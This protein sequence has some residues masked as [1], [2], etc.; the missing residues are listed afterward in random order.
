MSQLPRMLPTEKHRL[1]DL[2]QGAGLDVSDWANFK[3]KNPSQNPKYCYQWSF[4]VPN[5]ALILNIWHDQIKERR[6]GTIYLELNIR[7]FGSQRKGAEKRR[8]V[9]MD[10]GL[11][12]AA[13][14]RLLV[15]I[16]VLAGKR[17]DINKAGEK[18]SRVKK[19]FL[20]PVLWAVRTYD[21]QTGSCTLQRGL[22]PDRFVDQFSI[23]SE[24]QRTP[25]RRSISGQAFVRS[26]EVRK[27][28]LAR[29][30]GKCEWCGELGFVMTDGRIYVETHH[31]IP[32]YENGFD[33]ET[34][35]TGL[36]PN[37]HR[38]AHFG[39]NRAAMRDGLLEKIKQLTGNTQSQSI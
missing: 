18:A 2:V 20:D 23:A 32:L 22:P 27:N 7:H 11:Q 3:G 34:N 8:A 16:I 13:V 12:F 15:R 26:P 9:E 19:R 5:R 36:C 17:R 35:V 31:I 39:S 38:E 28:V 4:M 10:N 21:G 33:I 24:T 37:H 6:D 25:E 1:I 14:N 30:Q 29:A